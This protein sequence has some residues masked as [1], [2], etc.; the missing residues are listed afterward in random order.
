M[1][2]FVRRIVWCLRICSAAV[3]GALIRRGR[4]VC[5]RPPRIWHGTSLLHSTREFVASDRRAGYPSLSVVY[6]RHQPGYAL[7]RDTDFDVVLGQSGDRWDDCHWQALTHLLW[8]GDIW[9]AYFDCLFFRPDQLRVNRLAFRLI[10]SVGIKIVVL[11][12]GGDI[13]HA[14]SRA[15]RFDWVT[16]HHLDYPHWDLTEQAAT[17]QARIKFF[18]RYADLVVGGDSTIGRFLPR[19]D[20]RF[21]TVSMDTEVLMP[22]R[23]QENPRPVIVHAPNHRWVKGTD[24]LLAAVDQLRECGL[25]FELRL[26][27]Q[28]PRHQALVLY[29]SADIIADQF[30]I[31]GFG[32]FALEGLT[33]AKPVLTYLDQDYL[34][35]PVFNH[36]I[37]NTN[38]EN[39]ERV[40][41]VLIQVPE[42][43]ERLGMAG[44]ESIEK[45]QSVSA[46]A[47]VWDRVYQHVWWGEP[48]QLEKTLHFSP[49]RKPRSFTE[50]PARSDFWPVPV[51]DLMPEIHAALARVTAA[52]HK[53]LA[54]TL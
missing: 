24:H 42:L 7:V 47:E 39:L 46:L 53:E 22:I 9:V 17:A 16:R 43:R 14:D 27:E 36:P 18:S 3:A 13:I 20:L 40:L 35:D 26:V 30:C 1:L 44:R 34:G 32:V 15:T 33:L 12:H 5:Q 28:V 2:N 21:H 29:Q 37:V 48:L 45:Y 4:R 41:A 51:D 25:D 10:R 49:E 54:V 8:H 6:H 50:D 31:G 19:K 11:P 38:P 52:A 23:G